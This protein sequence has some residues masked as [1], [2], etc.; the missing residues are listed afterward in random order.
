MTALSELTL[1]DPKIAQ[2]PYDF[3]ER[4]R[5]EDPI[6]Y[7]AQLGAWLVTRYKDIIAAAR[8]TE[9]FSDEMRVS[10]KVR[11]P[12]QDEA[13]AYI[14]SKGFY[15]LNPSDSFKVDGE[16]HKRRR[17]LVA[18]AFSAHAVAAMAMRVAELCRI[19]LD[20]F[21]EGGEVD[22]VKQYAI[23]VPLNVICDALGLP[24][25]RTDDI[26]RA[27]NSLVARAGAG[28]N[29]DE[30]FEHAD[31]II[32]LQQFAREAIDA[33]R[34]VPRDDL[35]S[36]VVNTGLEAADEEQLT[37]QELISIISVSIAGGVD[38]TRNTIAYALYT[39]ATRPDLFKRI[40]ESSDQDKDIAA[41]CEESLRY[42]SA[43]PAL[44]RVVTKDT[45]LGGKK[46]SK[47]SLVFLCWASGNRDPER[48][49][50]PDEFSLDRTSSGQ[51]LAFGTGVHVC[52]GAML[53]RNEVKAAIKEFVNAVDSV[54]LAVMQSELDYSGSL[55]I[56][57]GLRSL[58]VHLRM[59]T[60]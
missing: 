50:N 49:E 10:A 21:R 24:L 38:T 16:L 35:I 51:H 45:E 30:A 40:Q 41:L 44:P 31:N 19:Q 17:K 53:A 15:D 54:E 2:N 34:K 33:R 28:A 58:P 14:R 29:R 48:F 20:T 4:L 6:H 59:K 56:L 9:T 47:D 46:I 23:P 7:D 36:H 3:Y 57:R 18:H 26:S 43:V 13:N 55:P 1:I 39:L 5:S 11:S 42:Y 37:E 60:S 25:D 8:D 52:L 32:Q 22:L 27:A 12:Y